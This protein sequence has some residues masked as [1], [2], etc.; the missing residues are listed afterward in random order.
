[1]AKNFEFYVK[2]P[3]TGDVKKISFTEK[4]KEK[5]VY[6]P[7]YKEKK[8]RPSKKI[9]KDKEVGELLNEIIDP[10][11]IN[12]EQLKIK[13]HLCPKIWDEDDEMRPDVRQALLK[14]AFEFI[15][16]ANLEDATFKDIILTGSLANYNWHEGSDLDVHVLMDYDQISD[17]NEFVG[18]YFKT[19][20]ALWGDRLPIKVMGHDVELYIQDTNEPHTSTGVYSILNN[21]WLTKP[22]HTMVALDIPNIQ[23]KTTEFMDVIDDLESNAN[24]VSSVEEI[25]RIMDKLKAYR[26][27]GLDDEGEYSTENLVF[28]MLRNTGYLEKLADLKQNV[29]TKKLT[30]ENISMYDGG[31]LK[32]NIREMAIKD[33]VKKA[34]RTGTVALGIVVAVLAAGVSQQDAIREL[35][36]PPDIVQKAE[37][38]LKTNVFTDLGLE[39]K[40][41]TEINPIK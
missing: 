26:K 14:N 30:L 38:F 21:D 1:M 22:I 40:K 15:K 23:A 6:E 16:F 5:E 35:N 27:A 10:D 36:I 34:A 8:E 12:V 18:D 7:A 2:D 41:Q 11:E 20:K 32:G 19:K 29:L 25:E 39:D 3:K 17:D 31:T 37:N 33:A 28:K 9:W 4:E 13:D 24:L